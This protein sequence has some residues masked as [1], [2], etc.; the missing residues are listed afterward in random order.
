MSKIFAS[1]ACNLDAALLSAT[2]PLFAAEEVEAIEW[3]F[4]TLNAERNIPPWFTELLIAFGAENCLIGHGVFFSLF[5]GKWS[6]EQENW[7]QQLE[8]KSQYFNFDHITEHFGFMTGANFHQ[9]APISIP[10]TKT[11]LAIGQDR[12]KR[13]YQACQCPVGLENLA[14]AYSLEEIERHGDFLEKLIAPIN[15]FIILDLHNLYC[16]LHN[17]GRSF[18]DIIQLYPL[19]CVREIHI[20]GGSWEDSATQPD[21]KIR[22]DTHDDNVPEKVFE[23]LEKAIPLCP[24]LK[25]VVLEQIGTGLKT[26]KSQLAF[27]NDFR[28]MKSIVK[29]QNEK[30]TFQSTNDFLP[31]GAFVLNSPIENLALQEEQ[32]T[33]SNILET[34]KDYQHATQLLHTSTLANSD[35][36]IESW[37]PEMLETVIAIAQKWKDGFQSKDA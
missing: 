29:F 12:L 17:F 8:K 28:R 26:T 27:Q 30:I 6:K 10:F 13:I 4:D 21:K 22:R 11:T 2:L 23:F 20:S 5:S 31:T 15:G 33:L 32:K 34:A 19:D 35:W 16:Q 18:E 37:Q 9:G 7:L 36:E 24:N 1:I 3:S 25:F 14:F